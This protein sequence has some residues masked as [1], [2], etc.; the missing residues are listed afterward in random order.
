VASRGL[1]DTLAGVTVVDLTRN[2]AGPFCTMVLGDLGA[3][4]VKVEAPGAG[5]DT[6]SWRP[7]EWDGVSTQFLA[8]N[9]NKRSIA[10]D[11]DR[12]EGAEVVRALVAR[13]DVVV[14]SFKP[15]SLARRGLG[16]EDLRA[17]N[18][19]LIHCSIS[20]FGDVGPMAGRPGYDPVMQAYS[21][22]MSMTGEPGRP[23]V[24]MP[25][26]AIDLGTG[27][28]SVVAIEAALLRR[29]AGGGGCHLDL[30]LFETAVWWLSYHLVSYFATGTV[31]GPHGTATTF[32]AP[33]QVFPTA[34]EGLMV[35]AANDG[36]FVAFCEV[37]GCP[38][39]VEDPRF[40]TN[41]DRVAHRD[42][43]TALLE[44]PL[45]TQPAAVWESRLVERAV[46]VSRIRSL[47]ET[48]ADPQADVLGLFPSVAHP[49]VDDL[50]LVG[51]PLREDGERPAVHRSP[52]LLGQHTDEVLGELGFPPDRVARLRRDGVVG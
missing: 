35:A 13:C 16:Y 28:W 51:S 19:D 18:S 23:A 24:R 30:S 3:E 4:V 33:Y 36:L 1:G 38:E 11:L 7:P 34:D 29:R 9:R 25:I 20:A 5:D 47:D 22:I 44:I 52:P 10:V 27:V 15:G 43:L 46:P 37:L 17:V 31:P 8:A 21:G 41:A 12:A 39:L 50:R 14:E 45:A 42:E 6:R 26:G 32:I 48:A 49:I 2:L 40:A